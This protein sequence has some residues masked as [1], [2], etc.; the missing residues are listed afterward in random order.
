MEPEFTFSRKETAIRF[1]DATIEGM[2]VLQL[3]PNRFKVTTEANAKKLKKQH[4]YQI[5]HK[6]R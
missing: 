5:V 1:A 2:V 4:G 3:A 6:A